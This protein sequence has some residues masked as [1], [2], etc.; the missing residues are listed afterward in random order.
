MIFV[1]LCDMAKLFQNQQHIV[2]LRNS[3]MN[4]ALDLTD[5]IRKEFFSGFFQL[6][7]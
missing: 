2:T 7:T 5:K 1:P 6:A 4:M 3:L